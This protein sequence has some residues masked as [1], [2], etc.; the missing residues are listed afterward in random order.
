MKNLPRYLIPLVALAAIVTVAVCLREFG[1][2][3]SAPPMS[4]PGLQPPPQRGLDVRHAP[5]PPTILAPTED[6]ATSPPRTPMQPRLDDELHTSRADDHHLRRQ[7]VLLPISDADF[8]AE[9]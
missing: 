1:D 4:V 8:P 3:A 7:E 5:Q 6:G 9:Q 2:F